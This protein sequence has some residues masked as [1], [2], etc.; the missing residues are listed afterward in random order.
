MGA[1]GKP[2]ACAPTSNPSQP[3]GREQNDVYARILMTAKAPSVLLALFCCL[4]TPCS[5][6]AAELGDANWPQFRGPN[7][8]G[9]STNQG[10]PDRWSATNNVVWKSDLQG[11]SW[12]SPIV[13]GDR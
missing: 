3:S 4:G 7:A 8:A 6:N 12:S 11:R 13:W 5:A 9:V 2:R 1:D 10:L